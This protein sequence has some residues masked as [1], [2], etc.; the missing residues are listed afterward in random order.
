MPSAE[1]GISVNEPPEWGSDPHLR[2]ELAHLTE[3]ALGDPVHV[4]MGPLAFRFSAPRPD[5]VIARAS[6]VLRAAVVAMLEGWDV[7][8]DVV[9]SGIPSWFREA[10]APEDAC[11]EERWSLQAWLWW[12]D[13]C[14]RQWFWWDARV[15]E[16]DVG[17]RAPIVAAS[18]DTCAAERDVEARG[19]T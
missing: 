14:E 10:C 12:C 3:G 16:A 8:R 15:V 9:P 6:E 19:R 17:D 7:D 2:L 18:L 1:N 13:P 4:G 11:S 5:E